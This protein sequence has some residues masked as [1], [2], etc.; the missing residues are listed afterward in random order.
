VTA[1]PAK[2]TNEFQPHHPERVRL[3]LHSQP[4]PFVMLTEILISTE[5]PHV[6]KVRNFR[7][8]ERLR[9]HRGPH[10]GRRDAWRQIAANLINNGRTSTLPS[11]SNL[12]SCI[13]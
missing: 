3:T 9:D 7:Q 6:Y 12:D 11:V 2:K 4:H 10:A 8:N 13:N 1:P 5:I